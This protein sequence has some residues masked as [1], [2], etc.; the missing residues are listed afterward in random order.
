[1]SLLNIC[2]TAQLIYIQFFKHFI[3]KNRGIS[4]T[5]QY[6][7]SLVKGKIGWEVGV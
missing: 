2:M 3:N 6:R 7:F 5:V 4:G 1:M